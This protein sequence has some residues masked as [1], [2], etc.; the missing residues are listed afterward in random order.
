MHRAPPPDG[1]FP[2]GVSRAAPSRRMRLPTRAILAAAAALA[3]FVAAGVLAVGP[4]V[5]SRVMREAARRDLEV[6][7]GAVRVGWFAVRLVDVRVHLRGVDGVD[8]RL[9]QVM[10]DVSA[11]LSLRAV[12]AKGGQIRLDGDPDVIAE[13]LRAFRK[14]R[15]TGSGPGAHETTLFV[16]DE[17]VVDWRMASGSATAAGIHLARTT[18]GFHAE[19]THANGSWKGTT[20]EVFGGAL[21]VA[22]E[23]AL[24]LAAAEALSFSQAAKPVEPK[25]TAPRPPGTDL[26]LSPHPTALAT[27]KEKGKLGKVVEPLSDEPVLPLPDLHALRGSIGVLAVAIA[28]RVPE[29]FKVNIGGLTAKL[30]V[31]GEPL[32]FGPGPF[33]LEWHGELVH[34]AFSSDK[35]SGTSLGI[36]VDLPLGDGDVAAHLSGGPVSLALLGV[37]DGTKGL[38]DVQKGIVSGTGQLVLFAKGDVMT[39]DGSI[40]VRSVSMRQPRLSEE[41][42]RGLDFAISARGT[43]NDARELRVDDARIDVG[44]LRVRTHGQIDDVKDH[45]DVALDLDVSPAECQALLEST[46]QGLLPLVR[47]SHMSGTFGA[48]A[49]LA[50]DTRTLDKLVLDYQVDDRCRVLDVPHDMSRERFA[51]AFSYRT[52]HADGTPGETSTG[53]G[54]TAWTDLEDISPYMVAAVLTTE[55]G[56]FYKHHGFNHAAI[57]SSV[58][59]NLKARRF[60]R[61]ASTI[62]MQLAKKFV[63]LARQD[64]VTEDRRGRPDGLPRAGVP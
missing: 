47:Q 14:A 20:V 8:V 13:R 50:F 54:S 27:A 60:V 29:G 9:D 32:T 45:F 57:R 4:L 21:E 2:V 17:L 56:A 11:S 30:D 48:T 26:A 19:C 61:G 43:L 24:R 63:S 40:D 35:A 3:V 64:L 1:R 12:S 5:R 22:P 53:P 36:E 7:V 44:A 15:G 10:A 28:G 41:P 55:D 6:T 39:F 37:K 59:A 49:H 52:Y 16:A 62:T 31:G 38:F 42:L 25:S 51:T 46:P 34:L 18:E 33:V 23:G 58:A